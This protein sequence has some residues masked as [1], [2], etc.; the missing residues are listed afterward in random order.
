MSASACYIPYVAA[1]LSLYEGSA[2]RIDTVLSLPFRWTVTFT[3][4][5]GRL[6]S[7]AE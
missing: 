5:P 3:T 7:S 2:S 4:S 6:L 1:G